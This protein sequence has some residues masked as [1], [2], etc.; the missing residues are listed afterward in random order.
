VLESTVE[1]RRPITRVRVDL[2]GFRCL[3]VTQGFA[4]A[5]RRSNPDEPFFELRGRT[6]SGTNQST[7]TPIYEDVD[8]GEI[9]SFSGRTITFGDP[10]E[11]LDLLASG[12]EYDSWPGD[13]D[14]LG[15]QVIR[16]SRRELFRIWS[17]SMTRV[18]PL[19]TGDDSQYAVTVRISVS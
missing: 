2:V 4:D 6:A 19:L 8:N 14:A 7:R 3:E 18:L 15:T 11:F 1:V 10:G 13:D 17:G 12:W 5:T 9:R 16:L